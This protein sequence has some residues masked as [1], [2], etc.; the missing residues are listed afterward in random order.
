[1]LQK[2]LVRVKYHTTSEYETKMIKA[3]FVLMYQALLRISE[4]TKSTKNKHN[5]KPKQIRILRHELQVTFYTYKCSK[6]V[7]KTIA[8]SEQIEVC[9]VQMYRRYEKSSTPSRATAFC[10]Q[11][12][13]QLT[14]SYVRSTLYNIIEDLNLK[15]SEYNTHSFRI[16]KATEMY[17]DGCSDSTIML[18]GRWTSSAYKKYIKPQIVR[19]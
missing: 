8:V 2:L 4:V 18:A 3:L 15:P 11:D 17:K 9:P 10:H 16:G 7:P 19:F 5:L 14:P 12:G 13:K 1:M 6:P